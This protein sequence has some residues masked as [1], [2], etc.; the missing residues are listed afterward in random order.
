MKQQQKDIKY[1]TQL[2]R[3]SIETL[4]S[5]KHF[6]ESTDKNL[7]REAYNKLNSLLNEEMP[8]DVTNENTK[9]IH[10]LPHSTN[11]KMGV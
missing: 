6:L 8:E 4:L 9:Y 5:H 1:L 10:P 7:L 2:V 11:K 3:L